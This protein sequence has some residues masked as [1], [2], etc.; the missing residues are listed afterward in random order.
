MVP[1]GWG[2]RVLGQARGLAAGRRGA[3]YTLA[4]F[5]LISL[6]MAAYLVRNSGL[7]EL[8]ESR[9]TAFAGN[10][11]QLALLTAGAGAWLVYFAVIGWPAERRERVLPRSPEPS[12]SFP[13]CSGARSVVISG[14]SSRSQCWCISASTRS[15]SEQR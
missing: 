7:K 12:P 15:A 10:G 9:Q 1:V 4:A 5:L 14:S 2:R 8:F 11:Y 13:C 6:A 3:L